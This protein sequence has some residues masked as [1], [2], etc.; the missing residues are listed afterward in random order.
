MS[1]RLPR[2]VFL[3]WVAAPAAQAPATIIERFATSRIATA[4][5]IAAHLVAAGPR[6]TNDR[7]G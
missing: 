2:R 1:L 3:Q 7:P 4:L 5:S 6:P